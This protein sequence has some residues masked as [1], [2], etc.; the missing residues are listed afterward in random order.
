M[1]QGRPS[2]FISPMAMIVMFVLCVLLLV[3]VTITSVKD[4]AFQDMKVSGD[5][6]IPEIIHP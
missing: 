3:V 4:P 5:P 6:K 2:I 1:S